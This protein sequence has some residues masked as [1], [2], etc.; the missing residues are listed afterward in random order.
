MT[1]TNRTRRHARTTMG[2]MVRSIYLSVWNHLHT[3]AEKV[4]NC[5][6]QFFTFFPVVST[7][8]YAIPF[9]C[10]KRW[11]T[12]GK[13]NRHGKEKPKHHHQ[14]VFHMWTAR[15]FLFFFLFLLIKS[16]GFKCRKKNSRRN[17]IYYFSHFQTIARWNRV[18]FLLFLLFF[19]LIQSR[20]TSACALPFEHTHDDK[21]SEKKRNSIN[22]ILSE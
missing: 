16:N 14:T 18:P 3:Q 5:R 20:T 22:L 13:R 2:E 15:Q 11:K 12:R 7:T 4:P 1:R 9:L 8:H 21:R 19:I 17:E 6:R 10:V